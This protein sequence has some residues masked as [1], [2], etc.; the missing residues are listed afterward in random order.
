MQRTVEKHAISLI[1]YVAVVRFAEMHSAQVAE[2]HVE[3]LMIAHKN[4]HKA[5]ASFREQAGTFHGV[6][7]VSIEE[8][9]VPVQMGDVTV[10]SGYTCVRGT[11]VKRRR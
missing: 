11:G 3:N 8:H 10:M 1:D 7:N 9:S 4:R 2:L 6:L 5:I